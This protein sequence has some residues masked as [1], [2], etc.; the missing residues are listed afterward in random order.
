MFPKK[1]LL[2]IFDIFKLYSTLRKEKY[3][4]MFSKYK[5]LQCILYVYYMLATSSRKMFP[6]IEF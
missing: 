3:L 5:L 1:L 4:F 2:Y 6:E